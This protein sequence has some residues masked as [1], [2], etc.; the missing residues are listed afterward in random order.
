[1]AKPGQYSRGS[2]LSAYMKKKPKKRKPT[3]W[4]TFTLHPAEP[5]VSYNR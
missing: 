1:M 3:M 2:K 4:N 5:K